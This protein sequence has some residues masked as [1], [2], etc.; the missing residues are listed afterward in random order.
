MAFTR[1]AR[2]IA[3]LLAAMALL[4]GLPAAAASAA[5]AAPPAHASA[6]TGPADTGWIRLAHLSPD[7]PAM[8]VY[9]YSFGNPD[10]RFVLHHVA[11]GTVSAFQSVPAGDYSIAMRMAGTGRAS[12][13]VLSASVTVTAGH[14]YTAA[15][16]GPRPG[17][18]LQVLPDDL[19]TPAGK[20]LVRVIQASLKQKTVMVSWDGRTIAGPLSFDSVTSYRAVAPGTES[21]TVRGA[22]GDASST[23]TLAAGSVH[24]LVVL[25]GAHGL[26]IADTEDAAG[27]AQ[28]PAG[29]AATGFGGTAPHGP[30]SPLPWLA[31]IGAGAL[32]A[33]AGGLRWRRVHA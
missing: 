33:A 13:P 14:A 24:T 23:L 16:V 8:D 21:V 11:Y 17:L 28:M 10:A 5:T 6:G 20:A 15:A 26:E 27:S 30:A 25:D 7:M 22:A 2:R 19:V 4:L 12:Q 31:L 1:T 9:L 32:L 29:G 3:L 18:R